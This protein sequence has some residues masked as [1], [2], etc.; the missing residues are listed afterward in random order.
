MTHSYESLEK[1]FGIYPPCASGVGD[2]WVPLL[3]ELLTGLKAQGY[4]LAGIAQIKEKFGGLRVYLDGSPTPEND[5]LVAA[6]E[7][8]SAVTCEQCGEPGT[9]RKAGWWATRCDGCDK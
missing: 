8:K 7:A 2:G 6:A 9:L 1:E 3:R 4:D 5:A